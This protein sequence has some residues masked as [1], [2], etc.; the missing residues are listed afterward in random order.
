MP[1]PR[2][3]DAAAIST[4]H[5]LIPDWELRSE[6]LFRSF[7]FADFVE[8]FAFMTSVALL[9]E[10]REHHPDWHNVYDR[11]EIE[12]S[13]HDA[14]GLTELDFDLAAAIDAVAAARS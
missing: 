2:K 10:K 7:S 14:G 12:L 13:T 9:A 11:V 5:A 8:A 3:L 4:A 1:R 6:S